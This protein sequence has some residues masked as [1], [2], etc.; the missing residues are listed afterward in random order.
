LHQNARTKDK[1]VKLMKFQYDGM[2]YEYDEYTAFNVSRGRLDN[3]YKI[4]DIYTD[5]QTAIDAYDSL[6]VENGDKKRLSMIKDGKHTIIAKRLTH[7][8]TRK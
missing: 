6:I 5:P 7:H 8:R 1:G 4:K 3:Q 2:T